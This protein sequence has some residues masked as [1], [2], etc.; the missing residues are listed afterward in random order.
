MP[1]TT[2]LAVTPLNVNEAR[3]EAL[4]ASGLQPS[5]ARS[6]G[7]VA[8]AMSCT[9]RPGQVRSAFLAGTPA[10]QS[11]GIKRQG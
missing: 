4:F 5:D 6:G 8:E 9:L 7:L 1:T 11:S 2:Q 10:S 3:C